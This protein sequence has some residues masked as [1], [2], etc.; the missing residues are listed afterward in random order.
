MPGIR[1]AQHTEPPTGTYLE[2]GRD[3]RTVAGTEEAIVEQEKA[4]QEDGLDI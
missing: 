3:R 2:W 4:P 1:N